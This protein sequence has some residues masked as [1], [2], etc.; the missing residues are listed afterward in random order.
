MICRV[1]GGHPLFLRRIATGGTAASATRPPDGLRAVIDQA[2]RALA[3]DHQWILRTAAV[4]GVSPTVRE[5]AAVATTDA[6]TVLEAVQAA[7]TTGLVVA[8]SPARFA[9]SHD[10]VRATLVDG[11]RQADRLDA[12]ARAAAVVADERGTSGPD[13]LIRRAH[14]ALAAAPRSDGDAVAATRACRSAARALVASYAYEQAG[15]LLTD[16]VELHEAVLGAP[17]GALLVEWAQAALLRGRLNEARDRFAKAL[18]A[19]EQA[20]DP[21]LLAESVLGLGGYWLTES[22]DP[23]E[24]ARLLALQHSILARLPDDEV[25]LRC[26]VVARLAADAFYNG[27]PIQPMDDALDAARRCGDPVA[28]ADALSFCHHALMQPE[29]TRRRLALADELVRV[30]AESGHGVLGLMGLCW[31]TLDLI[32]LGDVRATRALE[33]LRHR[34]DSLACE[35]MLYEVAV[36]DVMLRIRA[37]RLDEAEAMAL[38]CYEQ[39][40]DVGELDAGI[41]YAAQLSV[42][43]WIQG[44]TPELVEL[45]D[46]MAFSP[47]LHET[48]FA[49]RASGGVFAHD[50]GDRGRA[51]E[52]L[53]ELATGGLRRLPRSSTWL[54]GMMA[55]AELAALLGD[56]EVAAEAYDLLHPFAE[57]PIVPSL[58]VV[59]FGSTH[60][61][62]GLT[63]A[64]LGHPDRAVDHLEQAVAANHR[65]GNRPLAAM[66]QAALATTLLTADAGR[67]EQ[68]LALLADALAQAE[69]M[70][71][72]ERAEAWRTQLATHRATAGD[73]NASRGRGRALAPRPPRPPRRR[74]GR[75][76]R[77]GGGW[78]ITVDDRHVHVGALVGVRYLAELVSHPGQAIPALT[79][80]G[81]GDADG[82][83]HHEILDEDARQAYVGRI[84]DLTE[85]LNEAEA[86]AD[87]GRAERLR[88]ELDT[89]VH[90]LSSATGLGG[91]SRTF[92]GSDERARTAVRK[93]MMR[94]VE[95][96]ESTDRTIA[97]ILRSSI[98]TGRTCI[99]QPHPDAPI[100]WTVELG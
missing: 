79:L 78:S 100:S 53:E 88:V 31:R 21:L 85:E 62:L 47:Q 93:A 25:S 20:N 91:R 52:T 57:L 94:V 18:A 6:V 51:R 84:E 75:I 59:C 89:L 26:R 65:I 19:A 61:V 40:R 33:D 87:R 66:S 73:A 8:E 54:V 3:P 5:A 70:A 55:I 43:R 71:M 38:A 30:G 1:T 69:A 45:M 76:R 60:R 74:Q 34:A 46:D 49:F 44:R 23:V 50:A 64:A 17:P 14:H 32:D 36:I 35:A 83:P 24:R 13:A 48:D 86:H 80:A 63:A 97:D 81:H 7:A 4:L 39:G 92:T 10:L 98:T 15:R 99:Y 58:G 82:A 41:W 67:G 37:G 11:L 72:T 90:H 56:R 42:I 9:F 96:V 29:H 22:R 68:A 28:L 16:A 95:A 77:E 2:V 27:G 12:H